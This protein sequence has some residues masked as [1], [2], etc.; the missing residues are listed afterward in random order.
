MS[1][2]V[3]NEIINY[4]FEL[5]DRPLRIVSLVSSA[6]E[7]IAE[8]GFLD[9]I[10]GVSAYCGRY[11]P[12]LSAPVVGEYLNCD[13]AQIKELKPDLI[14][15]TSGVQLG[16]A[17]KLAK[18]GLPVY[19][20]TLPQTFYGILENNIIVGS[21]LNEQ[22]AARDLSREMLLYAERLRANNVAKRPKIYLELW[23][24]RHMR[25]IGGMSF[26][27]DLVEI[28]GGELIYDEL[29]KGY[30]KPDLAHV[31]ECEPNI[32]IFFHEPEYLIDPY[33]LVKERDWNTETPVIISTVDCG[34][35]VIQDGPSFLDTAEW[36]QKEILS[37][38]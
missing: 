37:L 30:F 4:R 17:A 29:T 33:Q 5:S 38:T 10:V 14:I 6:T 19:T 36:L 20:L 7:A 1:R 13:V 15:T 24:G 9:R 32:F 16:L 3:H 2:K 21:L 18:E 27:N 28:A 11:I 34:E 31:A 26:I 23:L 35:N 22:K 25:A 8:M 12:D